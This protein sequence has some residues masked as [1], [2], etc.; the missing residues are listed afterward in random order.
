MPLARYEFELSE[1]N[2]FWLRHV[3]NYTFRSIGNWC[4][5]SQTEWTEE[6]AK[7][8]N[9]EVHIV[10]EKVVLNE[11]L[12]HDYSLHF[13]APWKRRAKG[14]WFERNL[15]HF[16]SKWIF[17]FG[18]IETINYVCF[19]KVESI[20]IPCKDSVKMVIHCSLFKASS[21]CSMKERWGV[22]KDRSRWE[23]CHC[24]K[25]GNIRFKLEYASKLDGSSVDKDNISE[26]HSLQ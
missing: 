9:N 13:N 16:Q 17:G 18:N 1:V 21:Q 10:P 23:V 3:S 4:F 2:E 22:E 12:L 20:L 8:L 14:L 5:H 15:S 6:K 11:W 7:V 26:Q 25:M 19:L 24:I